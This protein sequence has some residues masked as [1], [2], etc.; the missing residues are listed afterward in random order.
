VPAR[1]EGEAR[2]WSCTRR[3]GGQIE[4]SIRIDEL[5]LRA[6]AWASHFHQCFAAAAL[7]R[8]AVVQLARRLSTAVTR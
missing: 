2:W 7:D 5:S 8:H 3:V 4:Q 1:D 6:E